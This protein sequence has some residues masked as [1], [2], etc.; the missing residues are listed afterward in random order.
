MFLAELDCVQGDPKYTVTQGA[1]PARSGQPTPSGRET[2]SESCTKNEQSAQSLV[3]PGV[4]RCVRIL[5]TAP[6]TVFGGN[7]TTLK[8]LNRKAF[9][10]ACEVFNLT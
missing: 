1:R 5:S 7:S 6:S 9:R 3:L 2:R 8:S 4:A 10:D